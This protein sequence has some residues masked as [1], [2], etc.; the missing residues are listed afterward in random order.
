MYNCSTS[1]AG[2]VDVVGDVEDIKLESVGPG[3]FYLYGIIGPASERGAVQAGDY[4]DAHAFLGFA[5]VFQVFAGADMKGGRL[6]KIGQGLG[7][8][9]G[10]GGHVEVEVL[11]LLLDLLFEDGVEDHGRGACV[12][13]ELDVVNVL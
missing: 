7:E 13:H 3:L 5:D 8:T 9:V 10:V 2:R 12:F 1:A 4:G 11:I 6:G